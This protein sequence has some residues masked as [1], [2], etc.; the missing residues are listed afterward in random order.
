VPRCDDRFATFVVD[1]GYFD[2]TGAS[3]LL[4]LWWRLEPSVDRWNASHPERCVVP[5]FL[6]IDNHAR[7]PARQEPRGRP[8]EVLVPPAAAGSSRSG[9]ESNVRQAAALEFRGA[10]GPYRQATAIRDGDRRRVPVIRHA[11]VYPRVQPGTDAPLGWALSRASMTS[12]TGQLGGENEAVLANVRRW[13]SPTLRC[14][15]S[16]RPGARR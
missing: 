5:L 1:G 12:L 11:Y 6:H 15:P 13:F 7:E 14:S 16:A 8:L 4:E 3:P 10:F 2:N 9:H